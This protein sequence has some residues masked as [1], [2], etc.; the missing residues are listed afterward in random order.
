MD[1]RTQTKLGIALDTISELIQEANKHL[2]DDCP[3]ELES[4]VCNAD[5]ML[6]QLHKDIKSLADEY[7]RTEE[8]KSRSKRESK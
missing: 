7:E 1:E 3:F 5:K 8:E 6:D 4:L 2:E